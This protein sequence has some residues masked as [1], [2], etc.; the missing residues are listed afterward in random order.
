MSIISQ[1]EAAYTSP[2]IVESGRLRH[3]TRARELDVKSMETHP[4]RQSAYYD[5]GPSLK[6]AALVK[7]EWDAEETERFCA[8]LSECSGR[9]IRDVLEQLAALPLPRGFLHVRLLAHDQEVPFSRLSRR[10]LEPVGVDSIIC[11]ACREAQTMIPWI[12]IEALD[13]IDRGVLDL[14]VTYDDPR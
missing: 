13:V 9:P 12:R 5:H 1:H 14:S 10:D 11:A 2:R 4:R 3:D 6:I 8:T 7:E